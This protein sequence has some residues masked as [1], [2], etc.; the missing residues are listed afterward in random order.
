[1]QEKNKNKLYCLIIIIGFF[2]WCIN[3]ILIWLSNIILLFVFIFKIIKKKRENKKNIKNRKISKK[4]L[5][6]FCIICILI[7]ITSFHDNYIS[8]VKGADNYNYHV[9]NNPIDE[10]DDYDNSYLQ[11]ET[12]KENNEWRNLFDLKQTYINPIHYSYDCNGIAGLQQNQYYFDFTDN[13][14][15]KTDYQ[16]M[17]DLN[18]D[19]FNNDYLFRKGFG[20]PNT[21]GIYN[22]IN[23]Y[24]E[25]INHT[26]NYTFSKLKVN[27]GLS[28]K[29]GTLNKLDNNYTQINS[30]YSIF[31]NF[32][33]NYDLTET[34]NIT[35]FDIYLNSS[36][37]SVFLLLNYN[38]M[39]IQY[40]Y[41]LN[42]QFRFWKET[43]SFS[44]NSIDL[45]IKKN[46]FYLLYKSG[47]NYYINQIGI[48]NKT[49]VN[50]FSLPT[51]DYNGITFDKVSGYFALNSFTDS[52]IVYTQ[53]FSSFLE[54]GLLPKTLFAFTNE[55]NGLTYILTSNQNL[56]VYS[57]FS[58][59]YNI[60]LNNQYPYTKM[61][62]H[63]GSIFFLSDITNNISKTGYNHIISRH[64]IFN[65]FTEFMYNVSYPIYTY[66]IMN[67]LEYN[68]QFSIKT[69]E[70]LINTSIYFLN[71]NTNKFDKIISF[72]SNNNDFISNISFNNNLYLDGFN[73]I[74]LKI[75]SSHPLNNY[76]FYIDLLNC[77]RILQTNEIE[78]ITDIFFKPYFDIDKFIT[79]LIID[80]SYYF[81]YSIWLYNFTQKEYISLSK[82][83]T[84]YKTNSETY[85]NDSIQTIHSYTNQ[86]YKIHL[87]VN[88]QV[89]R[90]ID[91]YG[92]LNSYYTYSNRNGYHEAKIT[93]SLRTVGG[94]SRAYI[95]VYFLIY[96]NFIY[97]DTEYLIDGA[98]STAG[99]IAYMYNQSK[100]EKIDYLEIQ[101]G[102]RYGQSIHL[103]EDCFNLQLNLY[104]NYN[105]S[106][107]IDFNREFY[108]PTFPSNWCYLKL[109]HFYYKNYLELN[110]KTIN[111]FV[112]CRNVYGNNDEFDDFVKIPFFTD[113]I[114]L[115][116]FQEI[117][118]DIGIEDDYPI[119]P[120]GN[121]WTYTSYRIGL[122]DI[123]YFDVGNWTNLEF[124]QIIPESYIA[125]YPYT[126]K[127]IERTSWGDWR[128]KFG[129]L[130]VSFNIIRNG[131]CWFINTFFLYFQFFMFLGI[132][133]FVIL[134]TFIGTWI[135]TFFY[136]FVIYFIYVGL[137]YILW[138]LYYGLFWLWRGLLW[139]WRNIIYPF[140]EW[141]FNVLL[142]IIMD[143]I[144]KIMAFLI[145]CFI[146]V[147][148]LG[149]IDFWETY[150]IVYDILWD[151]VNFVVEWITI[152]SNNIEALFLFIL[153]YLL[154][155]TMIY[156]RYLY[157]RARGNIN[158]AEQLYYTFQIY[159]APMVFIF[160]LLKRL[161]ESTPEV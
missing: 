110:N 105:I 83:Y 152:F 44:V 113:D 42:N 16:F 33:K 49:S 128:I 118:I 158:R 45:A 54:F 155:A 87:F 159:I 80:S 18:V 112:G 5:F 124:Q 84:D 14:S 75:N 72:N 31:D 140:L 56:S 8:N 109:Y 136:N 78:L 131:I 53:K 121:Y 13:K 66:P 68:F 3:P 30:E 134:S 156:F 161:L 102:L 71:H 51:Y 20:A 77:T 50:I 144:I 38:T 86:K 6:F 132:A 74:T 120:S 65:Y 57:G 145:T 130:W 28:I 119:I 100:I 17:N 34:Y 26:Y 62:F 1:M 89:S 94:V 9:Y 32:Q 151:I 133:G 81:N 29:N 96:Y 11:R 85:L 39:K 138:I 48:D 59:Q 114:D 12:A 108:A 76:E 23:T 126:E 88:N 35:G 25:L 99:F 70:S 98:P 61:S 10:T 150:T 92:F 153:W 69:N 55:N 122:H 36:Q 73:N 19:S 27:N 79:S 90:Q 7:G 139:I 111:C 104:V 101:S 22:G 146:W 47:G 91:M 82:G 40:F 149:Q 15:F 93:Y 147:I 154:N 4:T 58:F 143:A 123:I 125:L 37:K 52:M 135:L 103:E 43:T 63:N 97:F 46:C 107:L 117:I 64:N 2:L 95:Y 142:P 67:D 160:N 141:C 137:I 60:T 127:L 129:E 116:V 41:L 106:I 157:S 21:F 24:S 115:N 148:T